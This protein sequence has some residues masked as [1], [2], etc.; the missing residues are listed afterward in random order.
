MDRRSF[1]LSSAA[2]F[3]LSST[4]GVGVLPA[5]FAQDEK[6][7][8]AKDKKGAETEPKAFSYDRL[9]AEMK[10]RAGEKYVAPKAELPKAIANLDYDQHRAIRFRP[11][12][13][14]WAGKAAFE[15]QA[16]HMGWLFKEPVRLHT[17][18]DGKE[19]LIKFTGE[20]FEY[21]K[22]L[23][24]ADFKDMVMPGTAGFRVHYPLNRPDVMDELVA[25]LGASYF[26]SL[27]R[28]N[29]YGLSAR[30]IAVNTATDGGEEFPRFTDFY[31]V[32]PGE[33]AK[34]LM[35]Y[36]ALDGPS[37]TGAFAFRITPG[38]TTVMDVTARLFL[39]QPVERLGIAPM[40]SMF[41]FGE[42]NHN[43]FD[44]YR[45]QVHDSDGLKVVRGTGEE[46][47]RD[48]NNPKKLAMSFFGED[49]PK[50]FGLFQRARDFGDYQDAGAAYQRR[51]S[52]LVEP[53]S[54][55]GKGSVCLVEIPTE[56]EV[57]DN[58]VAFW[59]P[60]I[61][62][63]AGQDL[64]FAYRLTWGE[65]DEPTNTLARVAGLRTGQGGVSGTESA[66][67]VRKFV[68]DFDGEVLRNL[69]DKSDV[70]AT[71]SASNGEITHSTVSSID[72][73]G[74]WRLAIDF[75]PEDDRPVELSAYLTNNGQRTSETWH[76][77]WRLGDERP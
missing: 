17:V 54:N 70:Q 37:L 6:A 40:T 29:V 49:D 4:P 36:A 73:N 8:K 51:P 11:D 39:R 45:A 33:H 13:A 10:A 56:L 18:A 67:D 69:S 64:E 32:R 65:V 71:V 7:A 19:R 66:A 58:I 52:L 68:V 35:I 27:G 53:L 41:L 24:A 38:E 28:G 63:K 25:F 59:M 16:F 3:V 60:D 15:L 9:S 23:D 42:N 34:E 72:A 43:A 12:H 2:G 48:L 55:W 22:P 1:L 62:T 61:E 44:D 75:K 50:A 77:Q 76:Y 74:V 31:V 5:A 57:N 14:V 26:R 47:W 46:I 21:R 30:G 20:D